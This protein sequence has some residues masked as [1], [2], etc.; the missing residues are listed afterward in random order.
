M[1]EVSKTFSISEKLCAAEFVCLNVDKSPTAGAIRD[2]AGLFSS[3]LCC[4]W[5]CKTRCSLRWVI[6]TLT[7]WHIAINMFLTTATEV[8][9]S[10][11]D[12]AL[13]MKHFWSLSWCIGSRTVVDFTRFYILSIYM[14]LSGWLE[15]ETRFL[16]FLWFNH[17]S[18][19]F[20]RLWWWSQFLI[21]DLCHSSRNRGQPEDLV[22]G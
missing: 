20:L 14:V 10:G 2:G 4:M 15:Q 17:F 16:C 21:L 1:M 7:F 3:L 8:W 12:K 5:A 6:S 9:G 22:T 18:V 11:Y 13:K 19:V